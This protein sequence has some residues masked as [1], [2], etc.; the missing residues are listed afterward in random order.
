MPSTW[1]KVCRFAAVV[2]GAERDPK[3]IAQHALL[4]GSRSVIGRSPERIVGGLALAHRG[5]HGKG[6]D[7][8]R[9]PSRSADRLGRGE[10]AVVNLEGWRVERGARVLKSGLHGQI[11]PSSNDN[12]I[13]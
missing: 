7:A 2:A 13:L 5:E 4:S 3:E 8:K 1:K 12:R 10:A 9:T 6:R 11:N